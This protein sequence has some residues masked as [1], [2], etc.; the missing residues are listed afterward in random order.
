ME[1]GVQLLTSRG[2]FVLHVPDVAMQEGHKDCLRDVVH[3]TVSLASVIHGGSMDLT[4]AD[5]K[6]SYIKTKS[7]NQQHLR[8]MDQESLRLPILP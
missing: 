7:T 2:M 1:E 5:L 4:D 3:R 6:N 8:H